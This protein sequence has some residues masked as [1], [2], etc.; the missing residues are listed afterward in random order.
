MTEQEAISAVNSIVS[1][2]AQL[3]EA[4]PLVARLSETLGISVK[5]LLPMIADS[6]GRKDSKRLYKNK[7]MRRRIYL[8]HEGICFHCNKQ[9]APEDMQVDHVIP[10]FFGGK[11]SEENGVC[12]CGH[13]NMQ[14][15]NQLNYSPRK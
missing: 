7:P 8:R 14:R 6:K 3:L 9:V 11:T 1:Y 13:C 12:S 15:Q 4:S 10:W 2:R 5:A